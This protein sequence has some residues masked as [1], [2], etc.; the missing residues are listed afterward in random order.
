[1]NN[2]IKKLSPDIVWVGLSTPKQERWMEAHVGKFN[3]RVL[4]G[5]GAAFDFHAGL[6]RQAPHWIQKIGMEWFFRI[7][8]E[9]NRLWKRYLKN[10]P[11]FIF[12]FLRQMLC[13]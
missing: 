13:F 2:L 3:A 4:I 10:N 6:V 7:C 8:I 5:V 12:K 11:R 1:L 9:P